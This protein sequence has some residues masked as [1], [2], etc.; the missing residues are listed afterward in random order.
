MSTE[1]HCHGWGM[2]NISSKCKH[3]IHPQSRALT[4]IVSR[5]WEANRLWGSWGAVRVLMKGFWMKLYCLLGSLTDSHMLCWLCGL[6]FFTKV[7]HVFHIEK[8]ICQQFKNQLSSH[9][10]YQYKKSVSVSS[11]KFVGFNGLLFLTLLW[12]YY[13]SFYDIYFFVFF[14][15]FSQMLKNQNV[16]IGEIN[17]TLCA[18]PISPIHITAILWYRIFNFLFFLWT[19]E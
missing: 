9:S 18:N 3:N 17:K 5:N 16:I 13:V 10:A 2:L 12:I 14:V 19:F 11:L 8:Q 15:L 4:R 7:N 6:H 1:A